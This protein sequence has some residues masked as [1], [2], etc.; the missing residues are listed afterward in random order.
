IWVR[1]DLGAPA[2]APADGLPARDHLLLELGV[3]ELSERSMGGR[4]D[5][6]REAG[7]CR[8]A[9]GGPVGRA[10]RT[11]EC[12]RDD[13]GEGGDDAVAVSSQ[14]LQPVLPPLGGSALGGR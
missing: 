3:V 1:E 6:E 10:Q 12:G 13:R 11:R 4:M 14:V 8:A 9:D 5:A 2:G 7:I